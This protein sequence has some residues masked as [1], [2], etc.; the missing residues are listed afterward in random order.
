MNCT[1]LAL[2]CAATALVLAWE[3]TAFGQAMMGDVPAPSP[4]RSAPPDAAETA[5]LGEVVVTARKV[6]ENLQRVPVAVTAFSGAALQKQGAVTISDVATLTPGLLTPPGLAGDTTVIFEIRG[7]VQPDHNPTLDPS[8]GIY[9]DGY[10]WARPQGLNG[11]LLDV[12]S[13]QTLKG[14]QGTLFGRNTTG[15]A[16][17]IQT[18]DPDFKGVHGVVSGSYGRFNYGSESAIVNLPLIDDK[19]AMRAAFEHFA[20]DGYA[21]DPNNNVHPGNHDRWTARLKLLYKPTDSLSVL[22]SAEQ[23][24]SKNIIPLRLGYISPSSP[25]NLDVALQT[26]TP[27]ATCFANRAACSSTGYQLLSKNVQLSSNSDVTPAPRGFVPFEEVKT[28]TYAATATLDTAF[29]AIKAIGGYR[30]VGYTTVLNA[31]GSGY[32]V[33]IASYPINTDQ[34]SGEIQATGKALGNKLD[35]AGGLYYF[36]ESGTEDELITGL[37]T[38]TQALGRYSVTQFLGDVHNDSK[39]IYGQASYHLTEKLSVTGGLRYSTDTKALTLYNGAYNAGTAVSI[40]PGAIFTCYL[41]SCPLSR[42]DS[43]NGVSWAAS[44]DYQLTQNSLVYVRASHGFRSG[45]E[46]IRATSKG[47]FLPFQPEQATSYEGGVKSEFLDH[48]V[49][50]NIAGYYTKVTDLQRTTS[51]SD[52]AGHVTLLEDNAGQADFMGGEAELQALLVR[53]FRIDGSAAYTHPKYVRYID[54]LTGF[55]RSHEPFANVP[56]WTFTVSPIFSHEFD[57]R[58]F[59]LRGDFIYTSKMSIY[60]QGFYVDN[61]GVTRNATDGTPTSPAEA[62]AYTRALTSPAALIVN[63]RASITVMNDRLE[64][65]AWGKNLTDNRDPIAGLALF[66]LGDVFHYN[67]EP[68]TFGVTATY[69]FGN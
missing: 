17:L 46:N 48:R 63:A 54:P 13:V 34:Y 28:Q 51:I 32:N 52:S 22:L 60:G 12:N 62:A 9:V 25:E 69:K 50:L 56:R 45:G 65:A 67:R 44:T 66:G 19:L 21:Y 40:P 30:K 29:G 27:V 23:F 43:F 7:Q 64:L 5:T 36:T 53:D 59:E 57:V 31:D 33:H 49:R 15:G 26:G 24:Q 6:E 10:Y 61:A 55:D 18:N 35:F 47:N 58:R 14:P 4:A 2:F 8:V 68:R 11:D 38:L 42:S 41:T 20:A 37:P 3:S 39:G 16:I 1:K